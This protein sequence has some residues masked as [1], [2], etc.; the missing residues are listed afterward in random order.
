M[1]AMTT[2]NLHHRWFHCYQGEFL[3]SLNSLV[4]QEIGSEESIYWIIGFAGL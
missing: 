3:E 4:S 1:V 2:K